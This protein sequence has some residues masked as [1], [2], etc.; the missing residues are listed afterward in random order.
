MRYQANPVAVDAEIITD[1]GP[2]QPNGSMLCR[3]QD[4]RLVLADKGKI[5]RFIPEVGDY[6]VRQE[7]GYEYLNPKTVFERKYSPKL[8]P[9]RLA[10]AIGDAIGE[11]FAN[12]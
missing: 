12:R 10:R 7:D 2:V 1:V 3:L 8:P 11:W 9:R 4:G 5:A 6:W